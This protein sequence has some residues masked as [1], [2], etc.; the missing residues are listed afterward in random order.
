MCGLTGLSPRR[1]PILGDANRAEEVEASRFFSDI[2]IDE[3][4]PEGITGAGSKPKE[5]VVAL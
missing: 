3:S 5:E 4:D 2:S 1:F